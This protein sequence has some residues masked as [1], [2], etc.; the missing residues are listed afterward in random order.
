MNAEERAFFQHALKYE[1]E[2]LKAVNNEED[3]ETGDT[4][5]GTPDDDL[6]NGLY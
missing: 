5:T 3:E 4:T 6:E 2:G 1:I